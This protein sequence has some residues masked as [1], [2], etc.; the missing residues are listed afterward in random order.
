MREIINTSKAFIKNKQRNFV[1]FS[2]I[3]SAIV[4]IALGKL[5]AVYISPKDFGTYNLSMATYFLFFSLFFSP[6]LQYIKAHNH[7]LKEIG[8]KNIIKLF[9]L[10]YI[11][12]AIMMF[13]ILDWQQKLTQHTYFIILI[14][15]IANILFNVFS[16]YFNITGKLNLFSWANILKALAGLASIYALHQFCS[17]FFSSADILWLVQFFG[18]L[19]GIIFFIKA[20]P[21]YLTSLEKFSPF[22]RE[23]FKYALPLMV[24]AFWTWINTYIDRFVIEY[25][26]STKE[27]GIYNANLGLGSKFFLMINP[28]FLALITQTSF[29][30]EIKLES[31]KKHIIKYA[32]FYTIISLLGIVILAL[33]YNLVGKIFL[34]KNYSDGFYIIFWTALS[35]FVITLTY[36]YEIIFYA[37]KNTKIILIAN[38]IAALINLSLN[39]V[40]IPKL[41]LVGALIGLMIASVI[42]LSY[43]YFQF[44]R[45]VA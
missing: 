34:S 33:S 40:L 44:K 35:Y 17:Y 9:I 21:L 37:A 24:L 8:H 42:K 30:N 14:T 4:T 43:V 3:F 22:F 39:L 29:N 15:L 11:V 32:K 13:W 27:V 31:R 19:L 10:F 16:D 26:L 12:V 38:I 6:A 18:F 1:I 7:E 36:F 5:I 45:K 2:Q 28:L 25:Y 20:Y 41:H 23:Y